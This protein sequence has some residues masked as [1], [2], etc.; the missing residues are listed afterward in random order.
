MTGRQHKLYEAQERRQKLVFP[1][2][3]IAF[4]KS[5]ASQDVTAMQAWVDGQISF[6]RLCKIVAYNNYLEQMWPNGVPH[7]IMINELKIT[8]WMPEENR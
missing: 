8:G 3:R 2:D 4:C 6:E 1:P 5:G 7:S